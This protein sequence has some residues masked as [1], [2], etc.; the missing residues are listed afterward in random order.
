MNEVDDFIYQYAGEQRAILFHFHN[1]LTKELNLFDKIRFKIPFYFQKSWICYLN[2]VKNEGVEL[3]FLR[4]NELAKN[5]LLD[6]KD[7]KQV[8]GIT[9]Y[10]LTDIPTEELN[11]IFQEAILLDEKVPYQSKRKK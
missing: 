4:G 3:C 8:C 1:I 9:F 10:Q 6:F 5:D 11:V 7:R 2:P